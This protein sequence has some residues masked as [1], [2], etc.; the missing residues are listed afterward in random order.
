MYICVYTCL[1]MYVYLLIYIY[2]YIYIYN[3]YDLL[4]A[5]MMLS[6]TGNILKTDR[7]KY[8]TFAT[9]GLT[10]LSSQLRRSLYRD[11]YKEMNSFS[12]R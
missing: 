9:H 4:I 5:F 7:H 10:K 8:V 12:G 6:C 11:N 1:F 3:R 2:I